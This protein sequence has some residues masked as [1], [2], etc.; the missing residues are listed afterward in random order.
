MSV[1]AQRGHLAF[2]VQNAKVGSGTFDPTAGSGSVI[3]AGFQR[4]KAASGDIQPIERQQSLLPSIGGSLYPDGTYKSGV[5]VQGAMALEPRL[6]SSI[7][8]L[9]YAALG[10]SAATA[11]A[12]AVSY[13]TRLSVNDSNQSVLPWVT[14]RRYT[15][16]TAGTAGDTEYFVDCKVNTMRITI[17]ADGVMG[18]EFDFIGRRPVATLATETSTGTAYENPVGVALSAVSSISTTFDIIS[19]LGANTYS[20]PDGIQFTGAEITQVNGLTGPKE[21]SIIGSRNM[22]DVTSLA[23]ATIFRLGYKWKDPALYNRMMYAAASGTLLDWN[24][25]VQTGA[26][27]VTAATAANI[28]SPYTHPYKAIMQT[29]SLTW[30]MAAPRLL[31]GRIL[32]TELIAVVKETL[33]GTSPFYIDLY[34]LQNYNFVS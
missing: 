23:R 7:G 11:S 3:T 27:A 24:P 21:E 9:L 31:P 28:G 1:P 14:V 29:Q 13:I 8:Y 33:D 19:A 18:M 4:H 22:D 20:T 10:A 26:I 6:Q 15:P 5:H 12:G 25:I 30:S 32:Q 16:D 17:P 2:A 34:N